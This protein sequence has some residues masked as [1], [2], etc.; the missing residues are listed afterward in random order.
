MALLCGRFSLVPGTF[1][2]LCTLGHGVG[3]WG[4]HSLGTGLG[5]LP[6]RDRK[7]GGT[8]SVWSS[9][10]AKAMARTLSRHVSKADPSLGAHQ[11]IGEMGFSAISKRLQILT[12]R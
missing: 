8:L 11:I 4:A 10:N 2:V 7:R 5:K 1:Q 6:G 9:R 12:R 3:E